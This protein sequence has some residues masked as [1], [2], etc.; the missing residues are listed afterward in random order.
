[1]LCAFRPG[2]KARTQHELIGHAFQ[3]RPPH[4][5]G[6]LMSRAVWKAVPR[7]IRFTSMPAAF[8]TPK[9][10]ALSSRGQGHAFCARR[11]RIASQTILPTPEASNSSAPSGPE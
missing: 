7:D 4:K 11:P 9:G 2:S 5:A 8:E 1:M 3:L 10:W 6:G